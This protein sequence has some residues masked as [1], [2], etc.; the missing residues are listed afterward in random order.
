MYYRLLIQL[1]SLNSKSKSLCVQ[2][3]Q[4]STSNGL[5][6]LCITE[7][8]HTTTC[9]KDQ[10]NKGKQ[11]TD[12]RAS[13]L[14]LCIFIDTHILGHICYKNLTYYTSNFKQK[15]FLRNKTPKHSSLKKFKVSFE[16][17]KT[18]LFSKKKNFNSSLII[19]NP[20]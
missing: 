8:S 16:G 1:S 7:K 13:V 2:M 20:K 3:S 12:P 9:P 19:I 6:S 4:M 15:I 18:W 17:Y 10:S 14:L 11:K 5:N